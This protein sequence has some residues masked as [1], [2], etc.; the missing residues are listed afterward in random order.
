MITLQL[1]RPHWIKDEGD[2][3]EDQCAH[4][5]LEF[6]VGDQE[7]VSID[8]GDWTVSA[9][10]LFLMRTVTAN[11]SPGDS[12]AEENF[13]IPCCGFTIFPSEKTEFPFY[14]VGCDTGVDPTIKH[15]NEEILI[16]L[17]EKQA[18]VSCL[19][20]ARAVLSFVEQVEGFYKSS[21]KKVAISDELAKQGWDFFWADWEEQKKKIQGIVEAEF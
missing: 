1:H 17:G 3:P 21:A 16:S 18:I 5:S 4:G 2:D 13:L 9:A 19:D 7:F 14:I 6:R 15:E 11:Y 10:A 8:D 20:W 12:L